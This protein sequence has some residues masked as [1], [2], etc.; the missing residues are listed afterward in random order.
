MISALEGRTPVMTS[1]MLDKPPTKPDPSLLARFA[2]IVGEKIRHHRSAGA[3]ALSARAARPLSRRT[4]RWCCGRARSA[5]VVRDPQAR[6]RDGDAR[7]CRRAAIPAW[8]AGR[9]RIN[10]EIVLSLNRLDRI[11]EVDPASNTIT[12]EA[13]VTLAARAR[14]GRRTSTG[15]IRYCCRRKAPAPSAAT[16][17]PTPAAPRRWPTASRARMRSASRWCSPTA[18]C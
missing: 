9:S 15:S 6:Q 13:G 4:R 16:S 10:G 3:G 2:A 12:C 11:R 14:G 1:S 5:E 8:S 18:A 17:R 7:S